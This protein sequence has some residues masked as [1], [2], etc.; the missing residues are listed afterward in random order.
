[1]RKFYGL[2]FL[3]SLYKFIA[4]LTTIFSIVWAGLIMGDAYLTTR[5]IQISLN[6]DWSWGV[7]ATAILVIGGLFALTFFVLAEIIE[8]ILANYD[9]SR[10]MMEQLTRSND[11]NEKLIKSQQRLVKSVRDTE[12]VRGINQQ[13]AARKGNISLSDEA[14]G[15]AD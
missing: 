8:A 15:E 10:S 3:S 9:V 7:Q 11:L 14:W 13:I 6:G 12:T 2:K 4:L 1:M 5:S